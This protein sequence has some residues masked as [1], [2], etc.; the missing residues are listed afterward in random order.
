MKNNEC[1]A[2]L[3][4]MQI[5]HGRKNGKA[6]LDDELADAILHASAVLNILPDAITIDILAELVRALS[7]GQCAVLPVPEGKSLYCVKRNPHSTEEWRNVR[8]AIAYTL[9]DGSEEYMPLSVVMWFMLEY[10]GIYLT[11]QEAEDV[12]SQVEDTSK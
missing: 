2:V 3:Q 4:S 8:A 6:A 9:P 5:I 12:A 7:E 11:C 1:A 10:G